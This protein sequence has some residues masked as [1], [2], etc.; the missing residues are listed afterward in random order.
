MV[1]PRRPGIDVA[2]FDEQG[3]NA[4][5][6]QVAQQPRAGHSGT[7]D[8]NAGGENGH[9]CPCSIDKNENKQIMRPEP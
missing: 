5:Q 7:D 6:G 9:E 3:L 8:Q 1:S 2:L 4:A